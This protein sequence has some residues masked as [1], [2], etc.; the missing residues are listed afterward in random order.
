MV[1]IAM[2]AQPGVVMAC[3]KPL[4]GAGAQPG[5][6]IAAEG[7]RATPQAAADADHKPAEEIDPMRALIALKLV[8][9][10]FT[11][12]EAQQAAVELTDDDIA[13]L[14]ENERMMQRAGDL[15]NVGAA[16]LI[17]TLIVVG[18]VIL[19]ANGSGFVVTN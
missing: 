1:A 9:L 12:A 13:V 10:G 3:A 8:E 4:P 6:S 19:A 5:Q 2:L 11:G 15:S 14:R 18:I 7:E 17:G 16:Y